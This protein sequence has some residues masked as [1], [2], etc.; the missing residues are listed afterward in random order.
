MRKMFFGF[1]FYGLGLVLAEHKHKPTNFCWLR[2]TKLYPMLYWLN[3]LTLEELLLANF[4]TNLLACL[5][6]S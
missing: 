4:A 1:S 5:L 2:R 6:H 3:F